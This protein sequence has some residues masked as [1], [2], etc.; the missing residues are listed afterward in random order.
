M[1]SALIGVAVNRISGNTLYSFLDLPI[2]Q[3]LLDL[4]PLLVNRAKTL[5]KNISEAVYLVINEKSIIGLRILS[6]INRRLRELFP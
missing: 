4:Y 5:R 3:T 1:R 2:T 6:F